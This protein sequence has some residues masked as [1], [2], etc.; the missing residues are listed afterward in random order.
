M[1]LALGCD[2]EGYTR[3]DDLHNLPF[4]DNSC[5]HIVADK[6][7]QRVKP[8]EIFQV[9]DDIWRIMQDKCE[10]EIITPY[11]DAFRFD[12]S[13]CIHFIAPAWWHFDPSKNFYQIH[14]PKPWKLMRGEDN[15]KFME[16]KVILRKLKE[17]ENGN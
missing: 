13:N 1:R 10:M 4:E 6:C 14:R 8:W 15:D 11:G 2:R 12:P 16:L 9:M 7:L 17:T 5:T 3:H